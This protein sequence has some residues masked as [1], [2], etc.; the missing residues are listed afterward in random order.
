[1][2]G[3][4]ILATTVCKPVD[5]ISG[6]AERSMW[7]PEGTDWYD[8]S[9]GI[10]YEGGSEHNLLYTIDENPYFVKAGAVIPMAGSKIMTLQE[11]SPELRLVV[12]PG[13]G[14]SSAC[15]YEDDGATQAYDTDYAVTEITKV[16]ADNQVTVRVAPRKGSFAGMLPERKVSVVLDGFYAPSKVTVNGVEVPYARFAAYEQED[17]KQ[18]WGYDGSQ[19]QTNIWIEN[20]AADKELEVVISYDGCDSIV[21]PSGTKGLINRFTLIAPE[22]KLNFFALKIRDFQLPAEFMSVA[23]CGSYITEKPYEA[24]KFIQAMDTKAMID[25]INSWEQ[26]DKDFKVKIAAQTTFEK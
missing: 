2:F 15:V 12:V 6:L 19:L 14:E 8:M 22:T 21:I 20:T 25:N 11:Q 13:K 9:T 23:Q 1:M 26:L 17:G 5:K 10:M 4:D 24:Q 7:F 3:D 18:V 16:T